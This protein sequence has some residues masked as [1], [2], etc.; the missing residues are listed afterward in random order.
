MIEKST[1]GGAF[2][3]GKRF[4][5]WTRKKWNYISQSIAKAK[6][7]AVV[8]NYSNSIWMKQLLKGMKEEIIDVFHHHV[9]YSD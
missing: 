3:L 6:H 9:G 1:S 8:G 7:V 5:S 4:V 2:F